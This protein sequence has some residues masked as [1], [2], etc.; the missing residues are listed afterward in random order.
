MIERRVLYKRDQLR[1]V[2]FDRS[3]VAMKLKQWVGDLVIDVDAGMKAIL[4][5]E[6]IAVLQALLQQ[7]KVK[8]VIIHQLTEQKEE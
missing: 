7:M 1:I 2:M 5:S 3:P 8:E 6:E 4:G